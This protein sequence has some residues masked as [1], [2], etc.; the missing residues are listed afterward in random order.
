[1]ASIAYHQMLGYNG[2]LSA[3]FNIGFTQKRID[4]SKLTFNNQWNGNFFDISIPSNEP[5]VY[6]STSYF[7]LQAGLNYALFVN[8]NV[9]LSTGISV[10]NINKPNESFFNKNN[11]NTKVNSR[12][13]FFADATIRVNNVWILNPNFYYST[14]GTAKEI[15]LGGTL[16]RDLSAEN[17]GSL[18]F[19]LGGY[20]RL[21]DAMVPVIG[22]DVKNFKVT[23]SYDATSSSLKNYNQSRGAYE[24]SIVK[25]GLYKGKDKN[26][27][28]PRVR[29]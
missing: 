3:G 23:F 20:Y 10:S 22:F 17:N 7:N 8:D 11:I 16:Q 18:Q 14:I 15:V 25:S 13:T 24:V 27:K 26:I 5:F 4:L 6:S 21:S 29:F 28:C 1:Y 12:Y 2:L 19:L 9:Y